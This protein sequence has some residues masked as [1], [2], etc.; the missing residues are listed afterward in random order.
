MKGVNVKLSDLSEDERAALTEA[1]RE[2]LQR[3]EAGELPVDVRSPLYDEP[4]SAAFV[5]AL[6]PDAEAKGG[7]TDTAAA[8][9]DE[10]EPEAVEGDELQ[11]T[12]PEV[13]PAAPVTYEGDGD[14]GN[15]GNDEVVALAPDAD[16]DGPDTGPMPAIED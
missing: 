12:E 10:V 11:A 15:G 13:A 16:P 7:A 3:A 2:A 6:D 9:L 5:H 1:Q 8:S 4:A 14:P